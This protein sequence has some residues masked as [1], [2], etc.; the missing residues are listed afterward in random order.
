MSADIFAGKSKAEIAAI[1]EAGKAALKAGVQPSHPLVRD[2]VDIVNDLAKQEGVST[3]KVLA[4]VK[5]ALGG[6]AGST[7]G[8]RKKSLR[9]VMKDAIREDDDSV[10]FSND[11][12]TEAIEKDFIARFGQEKYDALKAEYPPSPSAKYKK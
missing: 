1:I 10:S 7:G 6:K 2:I 12:P 8:T 5:A 11:T 4:A 9:N 3:D